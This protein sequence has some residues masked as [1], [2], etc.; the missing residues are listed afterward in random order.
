MVATPPKI[1]FL[2]LVSYLLLQTVFSYRFAT[3][4]NVTDD[5]QT[6]RQT[7]H[8]PKARP[9]VRSAKNRLNFTHLPRSHPWADLHQFGFGVAVADVI[10]RGNFLAIG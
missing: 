1:N 8:S 9:I 10:T 2:T 6:D 5:R 7:T 4:E 3:I